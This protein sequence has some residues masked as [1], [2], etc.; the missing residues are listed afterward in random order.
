MDAWRLSSP[1]AGIG[2]YVGGSNRLCSTSPRLDVDW[3][4]TQ[5]RRGWHLLPLWVG[6][7][8]ELLGLFRGV[9]SSDVAAAGLRG[10][11]ARPRP[12]WSTARAL[13]IGRGS[14]LYYD[15]EDYDIAPDDCRRA[16]L[17]FPLRVDLGAARLGYR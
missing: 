5:Q 16:A 13:G 6:P 9:M 17:S 4:R 7:Q 8:A 2:I 1:Y 12:R 11:S 14:T 10:A 3:V 15:L